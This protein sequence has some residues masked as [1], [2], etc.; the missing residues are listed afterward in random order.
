[1]KSIVVILAGGKG[2]RLNKSKEK[3]FVKVNGYSILE[4]TLNKFLECYGKN[5]LLIVLPIANLN[6]IELN[7]YKKYTSHKFIINGST[8]KQS[9]KNSIEYIKSLNKIPENILIHDAARPNISTKLINNIKNN[10]H[11]K[12]MNFVIPY[13]NIDSTLKKLSTFDK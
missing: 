7:K 11:K 8:R 1:M 9:V 5:R 4:H 3:Q 2:S 6:K 10:I 12:N 13:L